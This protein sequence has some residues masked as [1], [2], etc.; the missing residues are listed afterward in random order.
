MKNNP[1][2]DCIIY[3]PFVHPFIDELI[4]QKIENKGI[5]IDLVWKVL[6]PNDEEI[7]KDPCGAWIKKIRFQK[8]DRMG[9]GYR[10]YKTLI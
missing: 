8:N 5:T 1:F 10:F 7:T 2:Q 4:A 9:M 6:A 3:L